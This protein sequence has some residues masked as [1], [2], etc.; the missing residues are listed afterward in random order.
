MKRRKGDVMRR[1]FILGVLFLT[2]LSVSAQT[3]SISSDNAVY[4]LKM[5]GASTVSMPCR[6]FSV[7]NVDYMMV[8]WQNKN[9][10]S[11]KGPRAIHVSN[12]DPY[13]VEIDGVKYMMIKDNKDGNWD[14]N[15]ILGINDPKENLFLSLVYLNNDFDGSKLSANE[16]KAG[17]IRFAAIGSDGKL[18]LQDTKK[19]FDLNKIDYID[20]SNLKHISN[21]N[22][23][24]VFGHF[25]LYLKTTDGTK[26]LVVG[27]VMFDETKDLQELF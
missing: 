18:I 10:L 24:G 23:T 22:E 16:L 7:G 2:G 25:N 5:Q 26:K 11:A 14:K 20:L 17:G 21:S 3:Y 15:D 13:I 8:P 6:Q 19:D 12:A 27:K 4:P 1:F 9:N